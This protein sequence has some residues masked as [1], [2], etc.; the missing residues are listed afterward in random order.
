MQ[1]HRVSNLCLLY[2]LLISSA[3]SALSDDVALLSDTNSYHE[4]LID[5]RT[6]PSALD[7]VNADIFSTADENLFQSS[8]FPLTTPTSN[9]VSLSFA[10]ENLDPL[11]FSVD[12]GIDHP[13]VVAENTNCLIGPAPRRR[14]RGQGQTCIIDSARPLS[15]GQTIQRGSSADPEFYGVDLMGYVLEKPDEEDQKSQCNQDVLGLPTIMVCDSGNEKDRGLGGS[16]LTD[17]FRSRWSL[18]IFE[19]RPFLRYANLPLTLWLTTRLLQSTRYMP[20]PASNRDGCGV[21][22][23]SFRKSVQ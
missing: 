17:C 10:T 20:L 6:S 1:V 13:F 4:D 3:T 14:K 22:S 2:T 5:D 12:D 11:N 21:V 23:F 16:T 7:Q 9:D 19:A 15:S 18:F 8:D